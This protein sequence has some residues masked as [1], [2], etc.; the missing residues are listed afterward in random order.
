MIYE[1]LNPIFSP[2]LLLGKP[3][4]IFALAVLIS[5]ISTGLQRKFVDTKRM[6]EIQKEM[7]DYS[8]KMREAY[9]SKETEKIE[10]L[11]KDESRI[12]E[13]Q[14]ELTK[15]QFPMFYSLIPVLFIFLWMGRA[16]PKERLMELPFTLPFYSPEVAT[17]VGWLGW[18]IFCS[19]PI[20]LLLRKLLRVA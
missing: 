16:F 18:Y 17:G 10:H 2:F 8:K 1:L 19:L 15:L 11:K 13:L 9:K 12:Y 7:T 6:K 14:G 5:S 3:M 20:N 4:A